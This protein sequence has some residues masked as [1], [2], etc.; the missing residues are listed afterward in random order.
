MRCYK[1][2]FAEENGAQVDKELFVELEQ[3]ILIEG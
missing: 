2:A 3:I 1:T